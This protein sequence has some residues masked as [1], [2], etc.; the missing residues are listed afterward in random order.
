MKMETNFTGDFSGEGSGPCAQF[1]FSPP[2]YVYPDL[3]FHVLPKKKKKF[4][5]ILS[6]LKVIINLYIL[7]M[8]LVYGSLGK[9]VTF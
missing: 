7:W 5:T 3:E 6:Y 4:S 1:L 9:S 8:C 2:V